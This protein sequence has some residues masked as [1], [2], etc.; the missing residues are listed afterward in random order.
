[1]EKNPANVPCHLL[2][3]FD[4][5]ETQLP[6]ITLKQAQWNPDVRQLSV[7]RGNS[8]TVQI[9]AAPTC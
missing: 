4:F 2:S 1:M 3:R 5:F 7:Y 8:N 9:Y 6:T